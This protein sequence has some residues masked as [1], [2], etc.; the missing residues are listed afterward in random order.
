MY[1]QN[2][3]CAKQESEHTG[4]LA[5]SCVH[6]LLLGICQV[7]RTNE[8]VKSTIPYGKLD[9]WLDYLLN[10]ARNQAW[11]NNDV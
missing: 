8:S 5:D 6:K 1:L 7:K 11:E 2:K 10:L 9:F 3:Q 4:R